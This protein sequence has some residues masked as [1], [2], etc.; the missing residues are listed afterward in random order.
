MATRIWSE[1]R[2][3]IP[4]L[5]RASGRRVGPFRL[6]CGR[7]LLSGDLASSVPPHWF[8]CGRGPCLTDSPSR[9]ECLR[10]AT[11]PLPN[12]RARVGGVVPMARPGPRP[13]PSPA[14]A[15]GYLLS[16][17]SRLYCISCNSLI[18][19][20]LLCI[21][22]LHSPHYIPL[23]EPESTGPFGTL[24]DRSCDHST[25]ET[26][27]SG[28]SSE[29]ASCPRYRSEISVCEHAPGFPFSASGHLW[30]SVLRGPHRPPA[31]SQ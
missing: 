9:G 24:A 8:D 26:L 23:F 5:E 14:V 11:T 28:P 2:I 16:P 17:H 20:D 13:G 27:P 19:K 10:P 18:I 31:R 21:T 4:P 25:P 29:M 30:S 7:N 12:F 6:E 15:H 22:P 1:E 3:Q